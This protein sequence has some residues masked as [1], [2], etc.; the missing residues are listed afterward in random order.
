MTLGNLVLCL[1]QIAALEPGDPEMQGKTAGV[2]GVLGLQSPPVEHENCQRTERFGTSNDV[3][4]EGLV[5][6]L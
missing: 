3:Q 2:P 4:L 1:P 5:G 6:C